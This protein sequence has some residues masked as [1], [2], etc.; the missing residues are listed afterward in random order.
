MSGLSPQKER[1]MKTPQIR[2]KL[3][4]GVLWHPG[5]FILWITLSMAGCVL[6][7][8][9]P[10]FAQTRRSTATQPAESNLIQTLFQAIGKRNVPRV[11]ALLDSGVS[12]NSIK[13]SFHAEAPYPN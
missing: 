12:P 8:A 13:T 4:L 5:K 10:A 1:F 6:L 3:T 9:T 11:K 7:I 2:A